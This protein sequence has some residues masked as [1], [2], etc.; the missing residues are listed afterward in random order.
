MPNVVV[1]GTQWGDEGKG[2]IVDLLTESP[3]GG[4]LSRRQQCRRHP[5]GGRR[6]VYLSP[7]PLGDPASR[8]PMPHR[9]RRGSGPRGL[10]QEVDNLKAR[11]V[12]GPENLRISERTQVIMPYHQR[13]IWPGRQRGGQDRH[14][15]PGHRT[16][17]RRQGGPAGHSGGGPG[18]PECSSRPS[19]RTSCPK[20]IFSW[21]NFWRLPSP[22]KRFCPSIR[23]W[24]HAEAPGGQRLGL[25]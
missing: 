6:Q 11:G 15:R 7:D 19:W 9:Q 22:R 5:G 21:K 10:P 14:H 1:V 8:H 13:S 24:G 23:R 2:K 3:D 17:L 16:L 18:D 4:A 25:D 20:R 12:V